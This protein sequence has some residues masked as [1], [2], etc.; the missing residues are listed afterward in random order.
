VE[1]GAYFSW[2]ASTVADIQARNPLLANESFLVPHSTSRP[3]PIFVSTL[4]G[5]AAT[6][7]VT[8][9]RSSASKDSDSSVEKIALSKRNGIGNSNNNNGKSNVNNADDDESAWLGNLAPCNRSF[10]QFQVTPLYVGQPFVA[11]TT[12][13][14]ACDANSNLGGVFTS[15]K[16]HSSSDGSRSSSASTSS[17]T[18]TSNSSSSSSTDCVGAEMVQAHGGFLETFAFGSPNPPSDGGLPLNEAASGVLTVERPPEAFSGKI[19]FVLS[20]R[21]TSS[22]VGCSFKLSVCMEVECV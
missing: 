12:Y 18:S 2:N 13:V 5:P 17:G 1:P 16:S 10:T 14:T 19:A 6:N 15:S 8:A 22:V 9:A 20:Q 11:A 3:F 4:D 7:A 21:N